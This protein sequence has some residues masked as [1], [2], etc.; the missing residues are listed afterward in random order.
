MNVKMQKQV[1]LDELNRLKT[2]D[3]ILK[4]FQDFF[5][6]AD[7][8]LGD[9]FDKNTVFQPFY[10]A[11]KVIN[12]KYI[13]D[14]Q[15]L[16]Q[17]NIE[18]D[19]KI[20]LEK[21]QLRDSYIHDLKQL[22]KDYMD[23]KKSIEKKYQEDK[24]QLLEDIKSYENEKNKEDNIILK[25][26]QHIK[27]T[28]EN[29]VKDIETTTDQ[30]IVETKKDYDEKIQSIQEDIH[31]RIQIHEKA[32]Q[33]LIDHRDKESKSHDNDYIV[34]KSHY[35]V[36]NKS[37]NNQINVL[38]QK[39]TNVLASLEKKYTS[40]ITPLD[41]RASQ[42]TKQVEKQ[43]LERI[44]KRD[45][46]IQ[47]LNE[48]KQL[49]TTKFEEKRKKI[50]AQ[51]AES[52]SILNS[53]LSNY[54]ELT[55]DKKRKIVRDF[56]T[57]S[58]SSKHETLQ[59]NRE[60]TQLDNDLNQFILRTRKDI[61]QKKSEGQLLLFDLEK[62]H[63][64]LIADIEF[65]IKKEIYVSQYDIKL[66]DMMLKHDQDKLKDQKQRLIQDKDFYK[67]MVEAAHSK[68]VYQYETQMTLATQT[69][70]R[71][72]GQLVLDANIDITHLD[73]ALLDKKS[74]HDK[75]ILHLQH[76]IEFLEFQLNKAIA[77]IQLQQSQALDKASRTRD[78][79]LEE[80]Q[81]RLELKQET[82]EEQ[83]ASYKHQLDALLI[84]YQKDMYQHESKYEYQK[85]TLKASS[86]YKLSKKD[87]I[88][89]E[90]QQRVVLRRFQMDFVRSENI[91]DAHVSVFYNWI[92]HIMFR[93]LT[94]GEAFVKGIQLLE[95]TFQYHEHPETMR[96]MIELIKTYLEAL[97]EKQ[98]RFI[99]SLLKT[100]KD[101]YQEHFE[102]AKNV[103]LNMHKKDAYRMQDR[104]IQKLTQDKNN[105]M[106]KRYEYEVLM[107]QSNASQDEQQLKRIEKLYA[108]VTQDINHIDQLIA[109]RSTHTEKHIISFEQKFQ[110]FLKKKF[111]YHANI[112]KKLEK[113]A[114]I[115]TDFQSFTIQSLQKLSQTMYYTQQVIFNMT[116]SIKK[117]YHKFVLNQQHLLPQIYQ[118]L[119]EYRVNVNGVIHQEE[120]T[121]TQ[122]LESLI[123]DLEMKQS[124]LLHAYDD[125]QSVLRRTFRESL[126]AKKN[127][128]LQQLSMNHRSFQEL[129]DKRYKT[130]VKLETL[131]QQFSDK[132]TLT[133]DTL[134]VNQ[135]ATI[136][137]ESQ[138][139]LIQ[140]QTLLSKQQKYIDQFEQNFMKQ[141]QTLDDKI[142]HSLQL[143]EQRLVKY[144]AS[145]TKLRE[146]FK[147][148]MIDKT[149]HE[150]KLRQNHKKRV[151]A[152]KQKTSRLIATQK[153][154]KRLH[155]IHMDQHEKREQSILNKKH[156]SIE[157]WLKKSYQFKIKTLDFS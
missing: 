53:K 119:I 40:L 10:D 72:L 1:I 51:S 38:K 151:L 22:D 157:F 27:K 131:L 3:N 50:I 26:I 149:L 16:E 118:D 48:K 101:M 130:I 65:L 52:V 113:S 15:H 148:K 44:H 126:V 75:E 87:L 36:L 89:N 93:R 121:K 134:D 122:Q 7:Q 116:K 102:N 133:L 32:Y 14:T 132:K 19:E 57:K 154:E 47:H 104:D 112:M 124:H 17:S 8:Q 56:Q 24:Q 76:D 127:D 156:Q 85:E 55:N 140:E 61:K 106:K 4:E 99:E 123:H 6:C 46:E 139:I 135:K 45:V 83:T 109:S 77:N 129:K 2:S 120:Q 49:E 142:N 67:T 29:L 111:V 31:T 23:Q 60:L 138:K 94:D 68:D 143:I 37:L 64:T 81:L 66:M 62:N 39:K 125:E 100:Y 79:D 128:T 69:Q 88:L 20:Q 97:T 58:M 70:E 84:H 9:T 54:R 150:N 146:N 152:S 78:L 30:D 137:Q 92:Q 28:Y 5:A 41:T 25:Q 91:L 18:N 33:Q 71:D 73:K 80:C 11:L 96:Q 105:L 86:D 43:K 103:V 153:K 136:D 59:K 98:T 95:Y 42:L 145:V 155:K 34:I 12:D 13:Y 63:Q 74:A 35:N 90:Y 141:H 82:F 117:Q 110:Q 115:F 144:L 21:K 107:K 147:E 108:K 114:S